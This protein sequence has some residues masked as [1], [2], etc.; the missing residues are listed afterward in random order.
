[1]EQSWYCNNPGV[2]ILL[3]DY[4]PPSSSE[5]FFPLY[6]SRSVGL[7]GSFRKGG[8][9]WP[10]KPAAKYCFDLYLSIVFLSIKNYISP[11][12]SFPFSLFLFPLSF[13]PLSH[14]ESF[15]P[16][17]K[18][19]SVKLNEYYYTTSMITCLFS[20]VVWLLWLKI[21]SL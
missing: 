20:S 16:P 18:I 9:N 12:F 13:F 15:P 19:P 3:Q 5:K 4:F 10:L 11:P 7:E 14:L 2:Y 1:M 6:F 17:R 21:F 8:G